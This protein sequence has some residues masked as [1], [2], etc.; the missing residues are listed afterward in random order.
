ITSEFATTSRRGAMMASV[1]A[2]QG[3]GIL[4][5]GIFAV[6]VL[7]FYK[8]AINEDKSNVDYVWRIVTGLGIIPAFIG[9]YFRL[10]IPESPRFTIDIEGN[11]GKAANDI[12][13]VTRKA[14]VAGEYKDNPNLC[15]KPPANSWQDFKEYFGQ[16]KNAKVLIGTSMSWFVLDI[17]F[18]GIGLNNGIIL[19]AIG[20]AK[21]SDPFTS[22]WNMTVGNIIITM[23]GTVPGYWF[24]VFFIDT[25]GRKFIQAMGF[26]ILTFFQNFGPNSTTFIVPGEVFPTRY[27]STGHG[28]A[29]ASGKLGAIIAQVGFL[30]L[31]DIGGPNMWVNR[32]IQIFAGFMFLGFLFTLLIPETKK[33]SLEELSNENQKDFLKGRRTIEQEECN[34]VM[35]MYR[36]RQM[37]MHYMDEDDFYNKTVTVEKS[38]TSTN[39]ATTYV[40]EQLD[41]SLKSRIYSNTNQKSYF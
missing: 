39:S 8:Q 13:V 23:L 29:A 2:M 18:Y 5:A 20:F 21:S 35:M 22:L 19:N 17:A 6:V 24:T 26:A 16:W 3:F 9:L 37:K 27:R 11:V 28:I 7:S 36:P 31:K 33:K 12:M 1:F 10:T 4:S 38:P 40:P 30:T 32:L 14:S 25:L 34:E 15:T 41:S